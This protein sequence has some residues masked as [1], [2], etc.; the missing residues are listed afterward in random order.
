MY[1]S[2]GEK[3]FDNFERLKQRAG[4]TSYA[5]SIR[6]GVPQCR[7]TAWKKRGMIPKYLP[8]RRICQVIGCTV[9]DI[10]EGVEDPAGIE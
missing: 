6:A 5:V 1:V 2:I 8:L 4:L 9:D 7:F 10:Y 3:T